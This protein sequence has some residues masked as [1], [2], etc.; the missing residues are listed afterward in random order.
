MKDNYVYI[1][2]CRDNS[3]YTGYTNDLDKR[4]KSHNNGKGSKY[5]SSRL[6]VR[7]VFTEKC[8]NKSDALRKE[9]FI[10]TLD[11]FEKEKIVNYE[12]DLEEKYE[13]YLKNL[14]ENN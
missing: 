14:Q 1:L 3:Y 8:K 11:R 12:Y 6:P 5:T 7:Y 10:K 4:I 13:E 2:R 9:H